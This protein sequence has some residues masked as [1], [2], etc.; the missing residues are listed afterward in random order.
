MNSLRIFLLF[1]LFSISLS[2]EPF[3]SHLLPRP[4]I[5]E[6]PQESSEEIQLEC[7]SWRFGV[8]A[9]NLGPWKTIPVACAE[10]V[11]D[12]MTGRAYEIDLGRVANEAAIYARSVELSEDG[13]DV[14]VFDVDET[15]LSNLPYYAEHGYG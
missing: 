9:N 6:Y 3:N 12:Y 2:H 5:L 8:E 11:K 7:T 4:L 14:W 13:N 15:L 10:Y 1:A